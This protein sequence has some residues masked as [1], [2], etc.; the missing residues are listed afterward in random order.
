MHLHY[1]AIKRETENRKPNIL[2]YAL[3]LLYLF[4]MAVFAT[5]IA[6]T[7]VSNGILFFSTLG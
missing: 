7:F 6:T 3:C 1:D 2:F 4:T 5:D